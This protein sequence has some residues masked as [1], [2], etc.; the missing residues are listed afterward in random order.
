MSTWVCLLSIIRN[1]ISVQISE[2]E[3]DER[4][5]VKTD[6][7]DDEA[8]MDMNRK[9]RFKQH[10]GRVVCSVRP[11]L[12]PSL[13]ANTIY[14]RTN[15]AYA[16]KHTCHRIISYSVFFW[17]GTMCIIYSKIIAKYQVKYNTLLL[18]LIHPNHSRYCP[19]YY[20]YYCFI[21]QRLHR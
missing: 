20:Y 19:Y 4:M 16:W 18:F 7:K 10:L 11:M 2:K 12:R 17:P 5:S 21:Y 6:L 13:Q 15:D 1:I 9:E 8:W 14:F 3:K